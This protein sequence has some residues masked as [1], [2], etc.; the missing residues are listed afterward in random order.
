MLDVT[1][2]ATRI[3]KVIP[4]TT[5][6]PPEHCNVRLGSDACRSGHPGSPPRNDRCDIGRSAHSPCSPFTS[7]SRSRPNRPACCSESAGTHRVTLDADKNYDT[8]GRVNAL[9]CANVT[10]HVAQNT[11]NRSSAI[12]GCTTR[13]SGYAASQRFRK[14]DR[15][16]LRLGQGH[17]REAQEPLYGT[18]EAGLPVRADPVRLQHWFACAIWVHRHGN[19]KGVEGTGQCAWKSLFRAKLATWGHSVSKN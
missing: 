5:S 17:R 3:A 4:D 6:H 2:I 15:G 10:S 7:F 12:D 9:R 1:A 16:M 19:G 14:R 8:K 18:R 13:H 11:S